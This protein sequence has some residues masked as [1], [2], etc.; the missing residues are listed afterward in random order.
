MGRAGRSMP[1]SYGCGVVENRLRSSPL[2]RSFFPAPAYH[3]VGRGGGLPRIKGM[4]L[5]ASSVCYAPTAKC[6]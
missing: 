6:G 5:T 4:E 1:Q 2:L 3:V